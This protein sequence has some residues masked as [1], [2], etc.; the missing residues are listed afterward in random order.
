MGEIGLCILICSNFQSLLHSRFAIICRMFY[1]ILISMLVLSPLVHGQSIRRMNISAGDPVSKV[2][3][4]LGTPTIE[5]PLKGR[6]IQEYEQCTVTSSNKVV[7]SIVYKDS[8]QPAEEPRPA[9]QL[10]TIQE[11]RAKAIQGDANAQYLLAYCLQAGKPIQ[12]DYAEAIQW[13]TKAAL[14]NHMPSQHNLGV[15]Y[16][17]GE[18]VE[19]DY[20]EACAWAVLAASN[21]NNSVMRVLALKASEEQLLAGQQK[22]TQLRTSL[23]QQAAETAKKKTGGPAK[24][25]KAL[26][27]K[28]SCESENSCSGLNISRHGVK[29]PSST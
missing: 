5:F 16:M 28:D 25:K 17:T 14:Q 22:A 15:L 9:P 6:F 20:E 29:H 4:Q 3:S 13:Y 7:V 18:G 27:E 24:E 10:P 2:Y 11:I 8:P 12:Q 19:Q 1:R 26:P 23:Q 21:G